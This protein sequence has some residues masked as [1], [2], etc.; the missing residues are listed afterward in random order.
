MTGRSQG[1]RG[2][3]GTPG[4]AGT[5]ALVLALLGGVAAPYTRIRAQQPKGALPRPN[6]IP[7]RLPDAEFWKLETDISEPGQ[8]F[9]VTDNYTS[10]EVSVGRVS[11][12]L[13]PGMS[14]HV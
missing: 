7:D 10:N 14:W 4:R 12:M 8:Y 2:T 3:G 11:A 6:T 13:R 9:Q 5:V 1:R